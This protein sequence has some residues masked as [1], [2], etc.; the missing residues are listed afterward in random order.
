MATTTDMAPTRE[1][2]A[3]R[4]SSSTNGSRRSRARKNDDDIE[5]QIARLQDDLKAIAASIASMADDKVTEAR[6]AAEKEVRHLA[7]AG[8]Q[9]VDT[10]QDEF[11]EMEKQLKDTIRAKPLT[12]VAG[13]IA[14]GFC[15]ALISR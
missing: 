10:V 13:A 5:R 6:G 7:K 9:A 2:P 12:A 1:T 8:Q 4:S 11:G 3:R 15:L 14:I